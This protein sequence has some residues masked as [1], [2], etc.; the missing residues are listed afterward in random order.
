M[1]RC[2]IEDNDSVLLPVLPF[3]LQLLIQVSEE[4]VHHLAVGV[5]L[6]EGEV[7]ISKS[8]NSNDHRDTR[9]QLDRYD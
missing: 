2:I 9:D 3:L 1:I 6:S 8:V 5:G 7:D 4:H